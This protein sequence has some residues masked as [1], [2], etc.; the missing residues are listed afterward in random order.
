MENN[1]KW[2][3]RLARLAAILCGILCVCSWMISSGMVAKAED[4]SKL[5]DGVGTIR[6]YW[7]DELTTDILVN[8]GTDIIVEKI[9]GICQDTEGNGQ[10]VNCS[11][12]QHNYISYK[13]VEDRYVGAVILTICIYQPCN[14]FED[15]VVQRFDYILGR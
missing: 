7:C 14:E 10:I 9:I 13:G 5:A 11:D 15:D 1:Y 8:R 4:Y 2:I 12:P 6:E 3:A